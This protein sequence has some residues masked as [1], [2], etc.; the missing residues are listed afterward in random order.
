MRMSA[1]VETLTARAA[2]DDEGSSRRVHVLERIK[3]IACALAWATDAAPS[4]MASSSSKARSAE[5]SRGLHD[6]S[7][8]SFPS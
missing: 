5:E 6:S 1:K 8:R 3:D 4:S 2:F 7:G